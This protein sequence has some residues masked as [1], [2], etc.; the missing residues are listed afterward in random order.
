M[1]LLRLIWAVVA[2]MR[3]EREAQATCSGQPASFVGG[4]VPLP[5]QSPHRPEPSQAAHVTRF[6]LS[7]LR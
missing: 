4:S 2:L 7:H 3:F 1:L 6:A 5:W